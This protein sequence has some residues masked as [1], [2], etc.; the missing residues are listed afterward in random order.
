MYILS[1]Y[2]DIYIFIMY[3][4]IHIHVH[5]HIQYD[6]NMAKGIIDFVCL[7]DLKVMPGKRVWMEKNHETSNMIKIGDGLASLEWGATGD[8]WRQ[9]SAV[10]HGFLPDLPPKCPNLHASLLTMMT[11][12]GVLE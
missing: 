6:G 10:N 12:V 7:V 8:F 9:K 5:P 11:V 1:V 2:I 3:T 4:Y